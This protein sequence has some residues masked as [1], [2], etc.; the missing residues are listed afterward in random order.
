MQGYNNLLYAQKISHQFTICSKMNE[1][2]NPYG[3]KRAVLKNH[4]HFLSHTRS[5]K[6]TLY[7]NDGEKEGFKDME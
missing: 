6:A 2:I 5:V 1:H 4:T 7:W 3:K